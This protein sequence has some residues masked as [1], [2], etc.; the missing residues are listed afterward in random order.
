MQIEQE[1]AKYKEYR[2]Y[3]NRQ[4]LNSFIKAVP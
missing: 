1:N 3:M 4:N 2:I